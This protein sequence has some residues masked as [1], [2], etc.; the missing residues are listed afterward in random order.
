MVKQV[1]VMRKD[2]NMR[3]GKLVAQ[4]S[5]ACMKVFLDRAYHDVNGAMNIPLSSAMQAWVRGEFKKITVYVNSE[6]ELDELYA[7]AVSDCIPC[8][9]IV[10]NGHTEFNGVPT[11]T[12]IA[13]G[14]EYSTIIDRITG[15]LPLL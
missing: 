5:H 7:K 12:C 13:I 1:I 8:A 3:K 4:G 2:L 10:D 14:P 6:A 11:K 9:M 15:N